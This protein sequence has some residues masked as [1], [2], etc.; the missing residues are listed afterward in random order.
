MTGP[1][2]GGAR[3]LLLNAALA[4]TGVS[5]TI[6]ACALERHRLQTGALPENLEALAPYSPGPL[7]LD[8]ITG[9]PMRYKRTAEGQFLLYS[10]GWN[11][12]DDGGEAVLNQQRTETD[13][14]KG[15]WV[16][17][18]YPVD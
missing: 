11:E 3:Y 16:W 18:A 5:Q 14:T 6:I 17:P 2:A 4:Q 15:D 13:A 12:Q 7:P 10:V 1:I 9:K 8:V